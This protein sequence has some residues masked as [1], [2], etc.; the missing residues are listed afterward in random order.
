MLLFN[1]ND[2]ADVLNIEI[3]S[4]FFSYGLIKENSFTLNEGDWS[5]L[6][7]IQ[8]GRYFKYGQ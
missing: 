4:L 5:Y 2:F 1:A 3:D 6:K 7:S 8:K